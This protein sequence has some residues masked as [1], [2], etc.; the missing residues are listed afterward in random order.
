MRDM[1]SVIFLTDKRWSRV[2]FD[3]LRISEEV[4]AFQGLRDNFLEFTVI[5]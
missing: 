1:I 4:E 2:E 5:W 3:L